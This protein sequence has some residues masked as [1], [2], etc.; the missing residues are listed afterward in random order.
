MYASSFHLPQEKLEATM[1]ANG[2]LRSVLRKSRIS[3]HK[4][5]MKSIFFAVEALLN[6]G[7]LT[8]SGL[9]RAVQ[10]KVK[11][12][13]NI[14]RIDRLMGNTKLH[15]EL[16]LF[17]KA[18]TQAVISKNSRPIILIDWTK[19]EYG[20]FSAM[21]AAVPIDGRAIPI[22]WSVYED[23]KWGN[24]EVHMH[25]LLTL[26]TLLPD[27]CRPILVTDA[28]FQN[29]WF[30]M[31]SDFGCD[32]VGRIGAAKLK[33]PSGSNWLSREDVY[34]MASSRPKDLGLCEVAHKNPLDHRVVL[35]KR[36]RRNRSRPKA[37][38]RRSDRARGSQKA[39]ARSMEPWI[40]VTS[41]LDKPAS[42]ISGIYALRMRIEE[43]YR[44]TKNHRFG[45]SFED[46]RSSTADRY[47]VLL[48][49]ATLAM[50]VLFLIGMML[51][52][53]KKHYL[54][55]AN[56]VR[57]KRV[58]SLFFLGKQMIHRPELKQISLKELRAVLR[59]LRVTVSS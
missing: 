43:C 38:R 30:A 58:L 7:R 14:K 54:F 56:T 51:E 16:R 6:G 31:V 32:W 26:L 36:F 10:R 52:Q 47:A 24:R 20:K 17:F 21:T 22:L 37:P 8:C 23:S 33:I 4:S 45:W 44:D 57:N 25:F 5:R 15:R 48:L 35:G 34:Q 55:Q 59:H 49:I 39:K 19:I 12:K 3:V 28:G 29:P 42:E 40:L 2:I 11:P 1:R 50:L 46:A 27:G 9:G 13:H 53:Q 41:L 18:I